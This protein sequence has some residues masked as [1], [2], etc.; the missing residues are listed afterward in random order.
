MLR[1]SLFLGALVL[2]A[3]ALVPATADAA[4]CSCEHLGSTTDGLCEAQTSPIEPT[5]DEIFT[6][7]PWGSAWLPFPPDPTSG[8][9]Y[10]QARIGQPGGLRVTIRFP[11]GTQQTVSCAFYTGG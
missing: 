4:T 7:Q 10:Y 3:A 5:G 6:W 9:A 2:T 1:P 8:F 11:N